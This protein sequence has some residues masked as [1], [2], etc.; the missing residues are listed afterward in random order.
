MKKAL[1]SP[2]AGIADRGRRVLVSIRDRRAGRAGCRPGSNSGRVSDGRE[3][4]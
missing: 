3:N 1:Q 2:R 4:R